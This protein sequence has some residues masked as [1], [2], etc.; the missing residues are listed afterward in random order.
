MNGIAS[1]RVT[2]PT[3]ADA[4]PGRQVQKSRPKTGTASSGPLTGS[5]QTATLR[6]TATYPE[7]TG[8]R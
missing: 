5:A 7:L 8:W 2:V 6:S 4:G 1:Q 3:R